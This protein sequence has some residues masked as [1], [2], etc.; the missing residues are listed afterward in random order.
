MTHFY[1]VL[2]L[3]DLMVCIIVCINTTYLP[4]HMKDQ[5]IN[6]NGSKIF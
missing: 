3:L 4:F 5:Y 6:F 1:D 2:K